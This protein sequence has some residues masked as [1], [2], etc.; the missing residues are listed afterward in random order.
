MRTK[1]EIEVWGT[2]LYIDV[3]S[4]ANI[5]PAITKVNQ[6]VQHVDEVFSTYKESSKISQLRRGEITIDECE[7]DVIEV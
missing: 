6:Y 1:H 3:T 5:E 7:P 4:A 2:V